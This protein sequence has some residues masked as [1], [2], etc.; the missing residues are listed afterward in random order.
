MS[1]NNGANALNTNKLTILLAE[2]TH[3]LPT[4]GVTSQTDVTMVGSRHLSSSNKICGH[5][6]S[7]VFFCGGGLFSPV[8]GFS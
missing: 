5:Q 6:Q 2:V 4:G 1:V 8:F 7:G 3:C